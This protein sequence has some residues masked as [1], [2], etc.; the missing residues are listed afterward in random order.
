MKE[1]IYMALPP[2]Y[3]KYTSLPPLALQSPISPG[4]LAYR[5]FS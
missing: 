4:L 5:I 1:D 2:E 3:A